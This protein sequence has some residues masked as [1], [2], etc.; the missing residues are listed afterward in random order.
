MPK[1]ISLLIFF[2]AFVAASCRGDKPMF[3]ELPLKVTAET[4]LLS[5]D[6]RRE[7]LHDSFRPA[8]LLFFGYS[9]CPDFCPLALHKIQAAIGNDA[10]LAEKTRVIFISVDHEHETAASLKTYLTAFPYARGFVPSKAELAVLEK[11]LG[12]YSKSDAGKLS[13]SLYFYLLNQRGSVIFLLRH[14]DSA[15]TIRTALRYSS[16]HTE[17]HGSSATGRRS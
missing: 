15:D 16:E 11:S 4:E 2:T 6:G 7:K 1:P 8:T 14:D 10:S 12:A 13:H 9:R 17:V 3:Q 5:Q